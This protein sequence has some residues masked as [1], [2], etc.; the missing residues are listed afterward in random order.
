MEIVKHGE[1]EEYS[2]KPQAATPQL[3][4]SSWPLL[5]KNYD[6]RKF[7][8]SRDT[9]ELHLLVRT[10]HFTPI[11]AGCS[12]LKRDIK[13]Y[14]SSGVINLD[15]PSNPSS[16]EVVAWLKRMLRVEKTGHSG[17]LDPKVTGCLIVWLV[18]SQQ[19]AGKEYVCVIRLHDKLPGGQVQFARAL[20]TLTGAL[21]QRPP[22]ISAVKRQLRIRTIHESKVIEFDNDRHLGVFWVSCEAGTYIRTLCVHLGLL[23][24]VGAH[25][26][27]LR[28]V[29][30]GAMDENKGLV[31]LHDVLDAQWTMDNTRD[32]SYL[33]RV[34]SPLETLLTSYKRVVVKDSAVNAVCYGAKLMLPGLLRY[35]SEIEVHDE[36]VMMTTKGEAIALG[37]AQMSTVEMSTCD[38]G[39]VAKIKRCIMERDLYPRKWGLG[40]QASEKKKMKADG[41]LDKYGRPNEATPAKWVSEYKDFSGG[42][43][44]DA[45][46]TPAKPAAVDT[47]MTTAETPAAA[48]DAEDKDSKKRKK[49]EGE[50]AEEK[51]ERKRR[52]AEKKAAKAAKKSKGDSDEESD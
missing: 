50:T 47:E 40:P 49:H 13:S 37:I 51:A 25:M 16:H 14:I 8:P 36:V 26:Q 11:P 5:L 33:R 34:I 45:P 28:R 43:Q 48:S 17:T 52:K 22:L 10:G 4:T 21:F 12:P 7:S 23:L 35:E 1:E 41:K 46:A 24:G 20:E 31:T 18:K 9:I 38:H 32:E 44:A 30:S 3:D 19:G 27:E 15:K 2:I 6:K 29:R 42:A 39:V